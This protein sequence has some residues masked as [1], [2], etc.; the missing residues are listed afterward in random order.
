HPY[1]RLWAVFSSDGRLIAVPK[2]GVVHLV[3]VGSNP[4]TIAAEIGGWPNHP[5]GIR[6]IAFSLDGRR[7]A[8][9]ADDGRAFVWDLT[10]IQEKLRARSVRL[11]DK[12]LE[13]AWTEL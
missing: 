10:K 2:N 11:S 3:D 4:T 8:T 12:E 5:A 6:G 13:A 9:T 7:L 1:D